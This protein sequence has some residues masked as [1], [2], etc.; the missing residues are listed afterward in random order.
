MI[1]SDQMQLEAITESSGSESIAKRFA[2]VFTGHP[3]V[4]DGYART[5]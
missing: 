1:L 5:P 2:P 3:K 4:G